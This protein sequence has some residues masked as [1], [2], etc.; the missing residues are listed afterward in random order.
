M[1][2]MTQPA[3][4]VQV[5]RHA[6]ARLEAASDDAEIIPKQAVDNSTESNIDLY[7]VW[8]VRP[9]R[10]TYDLLWRRAGDL[11]LTAYVVV[12]VEGGQTNDITTP[13]TLRV[14]VKRTFPYTAGEVATSWKTWTGGTVGAAVVGVASWFRRRKRGKEEPAADEEPPIQPDAVNGAADTEP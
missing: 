3:R 4:Q 14:P 1:P 7:W 9:K 6:T 12:H 10:P 11:I 13:I 8:T 5:S 2:G